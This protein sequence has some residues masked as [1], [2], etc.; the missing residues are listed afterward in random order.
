MHT[1]LTNAVLDNDVLRLDIKNL[2]ID[3][4]FLIKEA[5]K[6]DN[7]IHELTRQIDSLEADVETLSIEFNNQIGKLLDIQDELT[8]KLHKQFCYK[9][10]LHKLPFVHFWSKWQ[11][12]SKSIIYGEQTRTCSVCNRTEYR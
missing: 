4:D 3:K 1:L 11:F 2:Q 5:I 6:D 10:L 7:T 9:K 8:L 12:T